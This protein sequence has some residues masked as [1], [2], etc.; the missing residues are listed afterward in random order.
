[1]VANLV[2]VL[3]AQVDQRE[4]VAAAQSAEQMHVAQAAALAHAA[5]AV[6]ELQAQRASA[7]AEADRQAAE[8]AALR[9]EMER[10]QNAEPVE[11]A[12]T[13]VP[14][15]VLLHGLRLTVPRASAFDEHVSRRTGFEAH[16]PLR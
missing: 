14:S 2:D 7:A 9:Q 11:P 4:A 8:A 3:T 10:L 5:T 15:G 12:A 13:S 16:I 1:M 6:R